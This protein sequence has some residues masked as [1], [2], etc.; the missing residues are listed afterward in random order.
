MNAQDLMTKARRALASAD[1][2]LQDG[3][4][5]GACNRAYYAMFDS[6]RAALIASKAPV[7]PEIAKTHS[8]LIAAFSLHL[9][10]TGL[11][12][13]ELGRA[14]NRTEDLRLV[15]DYKGDPITEE[16]ALWALQHAKTFLEEVEKRFT[17][18]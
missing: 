4:N 11:F 16:E 8:G 2:L 1:K 9:V 12:P 7:P 13:V 5:D 3:D 14:F 10:K 6:A 18:V 17:D 15:A